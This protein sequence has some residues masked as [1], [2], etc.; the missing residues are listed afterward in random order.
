MTN[1]LN[2]SPS[3]N[4]RYTAFFV[5][6][7]REVALVQG[8]KLNDSTHGLFE[9]WYC[10]VERVLLN[11]YCESQIPSVISTFLEGVASC[12]VVFQVGPSFLFHFNT[13]A[14]E[15]GWLE[16][17]DSSGLNIIATECIEIDLDYNDK[18]YDSIVSHW[19]NIDPYRNG[20]C[21]TKPKFFAV[22]V[23]HKKQAI[24]AIPQ[25]KEDVSNNLMSFFQMKSKS[26]L[27][28]I[29]HFFQ[30]LA[31]LRGL[32][33]RSGYR[34]LYVIVNDGNLAFHHLI[35]VKKFLN[36]HAIDNSPLRDFDVSKMNAGDMLLTSALG[37]LSPMHLS[38][39]RLIIKARELQVVTITLQHGI[40]LPDIFVT[41]TEYTLAWNVRAAKA[42]RRRSHK[43]I[44]SKVIPAGHVRP[45]Y[46]SSSNFL[47]S[48]FGNWVSRFERRVMIATNLHWSGAH[49]VSS[50]DVTAM[51]INMSKKNQGTLF[52]IRPH[53]EDYSLRVTAGLENVIL[54]D[55]VI[56]G[57]L[58]ISIEQ[59]L[60][61]CDLL[62]STYSTLLYDAA[63]HKIPFAVFGHTSRV[64][65][66]RYLY[67]E[68]TRLIKIDN[69]SDVDLDGICKE[70][71]F[72]VDNR[73][74]DNKFFFVLLA[75]SRFV[76][77]PITQEQRC[78]LDRITE[79]YEIIAP[80]Y[81]RTAYK[82]KLESAFQSA[83]F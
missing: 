43:V 49:C 78:A 70:M 39:S 57:F 51:I 26:S 16:I 28:Y 38:C 66:D 77:S 73:S 33:A 46:K 5:E 55:D 3:Y 35:I 1:V 36:N 40:A 21:I 11:Q 60:A 27:F 44:C 71:V 34:S 58:D 24:A 30:D 69:I 53:P 42:I 22:K 80:D 10:Q 7:H 48:K 2:S 29:V 76:G 17:I 56:T 52:L 61:D 67:P 15:E 6:M 12:V 14:T 32:S 54:I 13:T 41:V 83:S 8:V 63:R 23:S 65:D 45:E 18:Q 72:T 31:F 82:E 19:N 50:N 64:D 25:L 37:P 74:Y 79:Y 47:A 20:T 81:G 62:L 68:L 4:A 9:S 59:V 75:L